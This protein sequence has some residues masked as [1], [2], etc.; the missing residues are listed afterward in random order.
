LI[1]TQI[2]VE[3][4]FHVD[5][6]YP[7]ISFMVHFFASLQWPVVT[8]ISDLACAMCDGAILLVA[9]RGVPAVAWE[10]LHQSLLLVDL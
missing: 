3:G 4:T 1:S 2:V 8:H 10:Q 9:V 5:F 6:G 7:T